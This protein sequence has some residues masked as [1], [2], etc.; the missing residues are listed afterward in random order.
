MMPFV[1]KLTTRLLVLW[2]QRRLKAEADV[3]N[4]TFA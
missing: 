2:Q 1:Q 4:G 3:M